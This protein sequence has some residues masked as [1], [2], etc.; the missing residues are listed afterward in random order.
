MKAFAKGI[1]KLNHFFEYLVVAVLIL[2]TLIVLAQVI[3]RKCH[4]S[5]AWLEEMARYSMIWLC[6]LGA[7]VSCRRGS[8]I[9][10]DILY[11]LV[12]PRLARYLLFFVD[13]LSIAFLCVVLYSCYLY[14]PLGLNSS[15]SS[16]SSI[17]MIWFY[18]CMPIGLGLMLL[19]TVS[20]FFERLEGGEKQ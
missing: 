17:K 12:P 11:E 4:I 18:L 19:N 14:L 10:V 8:L 1:D 20:N 6:F 2:L 7:A 9:K 3:T 13:I 15:A 16:M 5:V